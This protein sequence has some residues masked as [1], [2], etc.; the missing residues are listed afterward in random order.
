MTLA[1]RHTLPLCLRVHFIN[2]PRASHQSVFLMSKSSMMTYLCMRQHRISSL[3]ENTSFILLL[4]SSSCLQISILLMLRHLVVSFADRNA[5][6]LG[7]VSVQ[8]EIELPVLLQIR[9]E[10][11][12]L[13][14]FCSIRSPS[15]FLISTINSATSIKLELMLVFRRS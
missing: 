7:L 11:Y 12:A 5:F 14:A 10:A 8:T 1:N 6:A 2:A 3:Q 4:A 15:L 13:R 9:Y